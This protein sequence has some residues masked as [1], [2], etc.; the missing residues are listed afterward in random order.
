MTGSEIAREKKQIVGRDFKKQWSVK[1]AICIQGRYPT[2][3]NLEQ[4]YD[5]CF[6]FF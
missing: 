3:Y 2:G 1:K 6:K 4:K 5:K